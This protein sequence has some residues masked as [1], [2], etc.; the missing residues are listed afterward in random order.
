MLK[1][2]LN[3]LRHVLKLFKIVFFNKTYISDNFKF[4]QGPF[5]VVNGHDTV[6]DMYRKTSAAK[7]HWSTKWLLNNFISAYVYYK[8]FCIFYN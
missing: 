2:Q 5:K 4:I 3:F 1:A 6:E 8:R 7:R